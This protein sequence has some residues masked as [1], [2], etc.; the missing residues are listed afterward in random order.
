MTNSLTRSFLTLIAA[1]AI[2]AILWLPTLTVAPT[3]VAILSYI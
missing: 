3:S 2:T 1:T